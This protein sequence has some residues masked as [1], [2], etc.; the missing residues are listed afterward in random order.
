[1]E[2]VSFEAHEVRFGIKL[3]EFSSQ[4]GTVS[5][6]P[7]SVDCKLVA[8][9]GTSSAS[10]PGKLYVSPPLPSIGGSAFRV[11]TEFLDL[12]SDGS[13]LSFTPENDHLW[14]AIVPVLDLLSALRANQF[15]AE[16]GEHLA[17]TVRGKTLWQSPI[18]LPVD[19]KERTFSR[20]RVALAEMACKIF[21]AAGER[22]QLVSLGALVENAGDITVLA[23]LLANDK[24][25][26]IT[27]MVF[28][29][30]K[31][32]ALPPISEALLLKKIAFPNFLIAFYAVVDVTM[33]KRTKDTLVQIGGISLRDVSILG[34]T[35]D[36]FDAYTEEATLIT[37]L[38]MT[39]VFQEIAQIPH[40]PE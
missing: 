29:P 5:V 3:P 16:G 36:A 35:E 30:A 4:S 1:M 9:K 11:T 38:P 23:E 12:V 19:D 40:S 8:R 37:G 14:T 27:P 32:V 22:N 26:T 10:V 6:N 34:P 24:T 39:M 25:T 17:V 2:V 20:K 31:G 33:T 15:L 21:K 13:K 18:E 7:G 28:T